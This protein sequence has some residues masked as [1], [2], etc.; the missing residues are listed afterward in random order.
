M[1]R[2][3]Q[4]LSLWGKTTSDL[5]EILLSKKKDGFWETEKPLLDT[6]RACS[7][8]AGCG[9]IYSD[10]I[11]W[12]LDRQEYDGNWNNNEI[13]TSY[14]LIALGD[15]GIKNESGCEWLRRNYGERWE[16][17][18]TT[19][20]IITALLKQNKTKYGE[21]IKDRSS[22]LLSKRQSGGW[23]YTAT[24]NLAIQAL[25][26][27]GEADITPS[28]QWL[29]EKQDN[30]NWGDITSTSLSLISLKMYLDKLNTHLCS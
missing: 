21:F 6:A 26:L 20:L 1:S 19:S 13:D 12:I 17:A 4:A 29:L 14:A 10:T 30:G 11:N 18:G 2:T 5:I 8:L 27:A 22:W 24:S 16:H 9:I 3:I 28:I 25:M 7:A 23:I 15:A